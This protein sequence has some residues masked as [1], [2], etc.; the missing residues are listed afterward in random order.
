MNS[1]LLTAILSG[2]M[3]M[4][5]NAWACSVCF[6]DPKSSMSAGLRAAI[7][8]MLL[9]LVAVL[10]CFIKFFIGLRKKEHLSA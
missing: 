8:V 5:H 7:V 2:L 3:L 1:K 6:G 4:S 9:I 10:G